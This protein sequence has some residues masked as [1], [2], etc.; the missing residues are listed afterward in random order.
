[1][2]FFIQTGGGKSLL[3]QLPELLTQRK[4][5]LVVSPLLSLSRDQIINLQAQ[6]I[7][8]EMLCGSTSK[9]DCS[10][11]YADMANPNSDMMLL[12]ITP[13]KVFLLFLCSS[14]LLLL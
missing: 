7:R 2:H 11:I 12:Y 14:F 13:E 6:N 8:A 5:T 9:E 10:R 4:F 1:M 3:Y